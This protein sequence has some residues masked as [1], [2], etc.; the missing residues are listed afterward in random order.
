MKFV[1]ELGTV[2]SL[3]FLIFVFLHSRFLEFGNRFR[4]GRYA[5]GGLSSPKCRVTRSQARM[6]RTEHLDLLS[7]HII[8]G[9]DSR[10]LHCTSLLRLIFASSARAN[11]RLHVHIERNFPQA[12]L[13]SEIL[14]FERGGLHPLLHNNSVYITL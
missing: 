3:L 2:V 14:V 6:N 5:A 4:A 8:N 7:C 12:K 10:V 11:K 1:S 9:G 13:D